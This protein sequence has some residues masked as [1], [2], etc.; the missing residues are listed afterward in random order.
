MGSKVNRLGLAGLPMVAILDFQM[1]ISQSLKELQGLNLEFK[2]ITRQS[3]TG[4]YFDAMV[5]I[6]LFVER[7]YIRCLKSYRAEN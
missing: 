4:A 3:I 5:A 2:L 6:L 1:S 7:P